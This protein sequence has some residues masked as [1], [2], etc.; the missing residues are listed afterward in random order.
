MLIKLGEKVQEM[1]Y[2][3]LSQVS[4]SV[5]FDNHSLNCQQQGKLKTEG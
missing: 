5:R 1:N 2:C 3:P 4:P